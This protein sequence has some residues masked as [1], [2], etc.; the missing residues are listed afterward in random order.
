MSSA[1]VGLVAGRGHYETVVEAVRD[2][3]VSVWISTANLKELLVEARGVGRRARYRSVLYDLD[4]LAQRGVEVRILHATLPSRAFRNRFDQLPGLV[5]GG[6]ELRMCPR[7]HLKVV[8]VDARLLYV[9]SANWTGAGLGAKGSGRRN[10]ELGVLTTDDAMLDD[11]QEL[12]EHVWRG[13]PCAGC[14]VRDECELPI[15]ILEQGPPAKKE[16]V[17]IRLARR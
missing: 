17:R 4:A 6:I 1:E 2:A 7:V 13:H 15:E 16:R 9:G 8:I 5:A 10:F 12:Y 11:A 14:R 3:Q